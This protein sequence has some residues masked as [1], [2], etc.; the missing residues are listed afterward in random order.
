MIYSVVATDKAD[1]L[2]LAGRCAAGDRAAQNQ[3]FQDYRLRVHA[4]LYR[5]LGSNR[6]MEDLVQDAFL[7]VFQSISSFRGEAKLGT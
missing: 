2:G 5:I 1:D 3:L 4:T 6:D 7:Q